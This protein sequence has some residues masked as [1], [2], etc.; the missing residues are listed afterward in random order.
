MLMERFGYLDLSKVLKKND[1]F[2]PFPKANDREGWAKVQPGTRKA[3]LDEAAKYEDF[4]WPALKTGLYMHFQR[5]GEN[6]PHLFAFFE[7]RSVLGIL[8]MAEC[9]EGQGRFIDQIISGVY[10]ICEETVWMTPFDLGPFK[11]SL[12]APEDVIVNLATS[13]TGAL[14][15]WIRYLFKEQF[16]AISPRICRRI[17]AEIGRRLIEPYL[18]H[19]DYWWMGFVET[20]RVN[21][22]NPWC[23]RNILMCALLLELGDD[24]RQAVIKKVMRSLDSYLAKYPPDGCCDEGPMYWGA[25]GGGLHTCLEL[26]YKASSG[27][28]D[29]FGEPIVGDIG[30]Y[31]YKVHIHKD[32]FVD[33]ADGDAHVKVGA[34][35][36]NYGRSIGDENLVALG[37]AA[38]PARPRIHNWF[39][40]YETLLD[41]FAEGETAEPAAKAPYVR[42]GWMWHTKVM[43]AR[44]HQGTEKGLF[45]AAKAG[46]NAEAHNH[47]DIGNFVVYADGNPVLID[48]GTEEYT[49]KTFSPQRFELWYLQSQYHNCPTVNGVLQHEGMEYAAKDVEYQAND[50][51]SE[52][53]ADI[54]GAYPA[55][56]GMAYWLRTCRLN[57]GE[58]P[59]VEITDE[60]SLKRTDG[61][62][63]WNLMTPCM[64]QLTSPGRLELTYAPGQRA[65]LT[66]DAAALT[67]SV[68]T[69]DYMESRLRGNWGDAMYRIV[70]SDKSEEL[71][72]VRTITIKKV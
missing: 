41:F 11:Q 46:N 23:N 3:W 13:E 34:T 70:L 15:A 57:R 64:P 22:W 19:D 24:V 33:F 21:N 14:L 68:E 49:A 44:E 53:K 56:S 52:M 40:A 71:Q 65:V 18:M 12:P 48:L 39:G 30:R 55:E 5:T 1:D 29:I 69:I 8:A 72:A 26:L 59:S 62:I 37:M 20:P 10:C 28:I 67:L 6:L 36:R 45:L 2:K 17:E 31:I 25:A 61:G 16:D 42:D 66:Y 58:A 4:T 32:W 38:Q 60:Y 35:T 51:F 7:R 43:T 50:L 47:N 9:M 63:T 27:A 54:S